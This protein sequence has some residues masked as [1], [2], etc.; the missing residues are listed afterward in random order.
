MTPSNDPEV[1]L[2]D[3]Q[4]I[5]GLSSASDSEQCTGSSASWFGVA[6]SSNVN[7]SHENAHFRFK[8][9]VFLDQP[10]YRLGHSI[11]SMCGLVSV[12]CV[13]A[14]HLSV[15]EAARWL[16]AMSN[17]MLLFYFFVVQRSFETSYNRLPKSSKIRNRLS[18]LT[19]VGFEE[20]MVRKSWFALLPTFWC[21]E[22]P[23]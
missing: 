10:I 1:T 18:K 9:W 4:T 7:Y 19:G 12:R 2:H 22:I 21:W 15:T 13:H 3:E 17:V 14:L 6:T 16:S 20:F 11:C 5:C 8:S 23:W